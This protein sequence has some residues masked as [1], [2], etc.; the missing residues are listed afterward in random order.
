MLVGILAPNS[1][2]MMG[3]FIEPLCRDH[4]QNKCKINFHSTGETMVGNVNF[5]AHGYLHGGCVC[6][7]LLHDSGCGLGYDAS[8]GLGL[9]RQVALAGR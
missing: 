2:G 1:A 9:D 6:H 5:V 7:S 8:H 3:R 4:K